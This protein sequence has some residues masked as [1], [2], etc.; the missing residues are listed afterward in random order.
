MTAADYHR[1]RRLP[2]QLAAVEQRLSAIEVEMLPRGQ[3]PAYRA[4]RRR[5][6]LAKR[7]RLLTLAQTLGL[8]D[9]SR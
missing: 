6:M 2:D 7:E 3:G 4:R 8:S 9:L 1:I 5:A